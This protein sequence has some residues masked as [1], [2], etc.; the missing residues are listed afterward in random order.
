MLETFSFSEQKE[1]IKADENREPELPS[2]SLHPD[3]G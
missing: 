2:S 3:E 1:F